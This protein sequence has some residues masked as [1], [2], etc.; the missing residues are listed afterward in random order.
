MARLITVV[1]FKCLAQLPKWG[2]IVETRMRKTGAFL[3]AFRDGR[4]QRILCRLKCSHIC[5]EA[6]ET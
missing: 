5:I 2:R 6:L 4:T 3:M 1:M